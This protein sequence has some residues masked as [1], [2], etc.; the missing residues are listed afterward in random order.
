MRLGSGTVERQPPQEAGAAPSAAGGGEPSPAPLVRGPADV[1]WLQGAAGNRAVTN[2]LGARGLAR[3]R[4]REP[5]A[6]A[7][8]APSAAASPDPSGLASRIVQ[9]ASDHLGQRVGRGQCDDLAVAALQAA[10]AEYAGRHNWGDPVDVAD[11]RPGDLLQFS[12][13]LIRLD[14]GAALVR[15]PRPHGHTAIVLENHGNGTLTV[16]EQNMT[17]WGTMLNPHTTQV[18]AIYLTQGVR[19]SRGQTVTRVSGQIR[20]FRARPRNSPGSASPAPQRRTRPPG[21]GR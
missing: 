12:E 17:D 5:A 20:A 21:R 9:F 10:G 7:S 6:P 2:M 14:D 11:V 18:G 1:L 19:T 3:Q 15:G 8:A 13:F 4:R 16:A